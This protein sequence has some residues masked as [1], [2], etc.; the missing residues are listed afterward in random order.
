MEWEMDRRIGVASAVTQV[1][2]WSVVV[3]RELSWKVNLSM[4]RSIYVQL[5]P[6]VTRWVVTDR[7]SLQIQSAKMSFLRRVAGLSL[8]DRVRSSDIRRE[9][10]VDPLLLRVKRSKLRFFGHLIR[11]PPRRLPLEVF[12]TRP[13]GRRPWG[14]PRTCWRDYISHLA[15]ERFKTSQEELESFAGEKEVWGALLSLLPLQRGPG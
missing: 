10:R 5:S 1:L 11:M 6:I 9:L 13:T 4:Y 7:T 8:R 15:W 12:W 3:K 2:Y 14:R